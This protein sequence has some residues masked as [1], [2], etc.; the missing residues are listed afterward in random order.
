LKQ[1]RYDSLKN[2]EERALIIKVCK[3]YYLENKTQKEIAKI[4]GIS[5]PKVS[6]LLT[7]GKQIG[8]VK[9][10]IDAGP[11]VNNKQEVSNK[12]KENYNL[13][14]VII[15]N[16]FYQ[17]KVIFEIA[18]AAG[19]F[20]SNHIR[21]GQ[22]VGLSWG[23]TLYQTCESIVCNEK[24]NNTLFVP[25]LGGVGQRRYQYQVNSI[26]EKMANAFQALRYYLHAPAVLE[27]LTDLETIL[28]NNAIK[29]VTDMWNKLDL[30][31]VGIGEPISLS[32]AFKDIFDQELLS[33]LIKDKAVGD[34]AG[35]F[36][37]AEGMECKDIGLRILGISLEQL[38]RTP[39]V[40]GIAGGQEK[41]SAIYAAIK[42]GYINSLVTDL[43]TALSILNMEGKVI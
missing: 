34:I 5:R 37:T 16:S 4:L 12:L 35:R 41:V 2:F 32:N 26:V 29:L 8:I 39:E 18:S 9:I 21:D 40:I 33:N 11:A 36:F 1:R 19:K 38:K 43:D 13:K 31:I 15:A 28:Q 22:I 14:N 24:Y 20:L 25:L 30:A 10:E 3:L 6:R 7:A 23:R 42:A 17:N 27:N